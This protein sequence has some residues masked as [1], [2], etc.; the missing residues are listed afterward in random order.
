MS[1]YRYP[2]VE[3]LVAGAE[4]LEIA[5]REL[6][7]AA[8]KRRDRRKPRSGRG[9][10]LRPGAETQLWNTMV[11]LVKPHLSRRGDRAIM[12]KELG[13]HRARIGEYFDAKSAMPDAERTLQTLIWLAQKQREPSKD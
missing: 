2:G 1:S 4:L 12:A 3:E 6:T 13:L 8:L 5:A 10:T 11:S 9:S 7:K